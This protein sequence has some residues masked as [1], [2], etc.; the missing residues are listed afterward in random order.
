MKGRSGIVA[1]AAAMALA[2]L[3]LAISARAHSRNDGGRGLRKGPFAE[4]S[5]E[6]RQALRGRVEEIRAEGAAPEEIH[7]A[8]GEMLRGYSVEL[9]EDWGERRD[10]PG[11]GHHRH[12][13]MG[14]LSDDQRQAVRER[15]G[16]MR[17]Q[18]A[19]REEI[20]AVVREM[21]HGFGVELPD[22]WA[23]RHRPP[24]FRHGPHQF[25]AGLRDEQRQALRERERGMR[26]EGASREEIRREVRTML[27]GFG[28]QL[29]ERDSGTPTG[30]EFGI[31]AAATAADLRMEAKATPN[32][33]QA[34]TEVSYA[35][36]VPQD[37]S[38]QVYNTAGQV[39]CTF[40]VGYQDPGRHS[41]SWD[42]CNEDGSGI[43]SGMY[44]CRIEAGPNS[45][46]AGPHAVTKRV[47]LLR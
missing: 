40:P 30:S 3:L 1:V 12:R 5:D 25:M 19:T 37:V 8:A 17:M 34:K 46:E 13:F 6:Q 32:P 9:P 18:E 21:L 23:E 14:G 39:I 26:S 20:R 36:S 29:P 11:F 28:V 35:L 31:R 24:G 38:V 15:I 43:P 33:F 4:L 27:E 42:G 22:D 45:V 2:G 47:V 44:Y 7:E 10:P 16:E 41:V